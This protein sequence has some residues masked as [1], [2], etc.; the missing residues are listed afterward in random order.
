VGIPVGADLVEFA[1]IAGQNA[2]DITA[3]RFAYKLLT[4]ACMK[5]ISAKK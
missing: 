1:P 3:A 2:W 5:N 4:Y